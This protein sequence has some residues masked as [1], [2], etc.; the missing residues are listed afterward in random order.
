MPKLHQKPTK[1]QQN[2]ISE[3][4]PF[5]PD[6]VASRA[7]TAMLHGESHAAVWVAQVVIFM[8]KIHPCKRPF[9]EQQ[10]L[11]HMAHPQWLSFANKAGMDGGVKGGGK[12]Q[13]VHFC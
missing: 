10:I 3:M 11:R 13:D 12:L 8:G 9:W 1:D 5:P 2:N 4:S 6:D 7:A